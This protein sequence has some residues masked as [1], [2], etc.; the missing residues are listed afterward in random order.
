M[1]VLCSRHPSSH[2][3]EL[4]RGADTQGYDYWLDEL[5]QGHIVRN[6]MIIA[7][8]NGGWDNPSPDAQSDMQRFGFRVE[9]SLAFANY[10]A[11]HGIV[12]SELS[13]QDQ[14]YL[15]EVGANIL[16]NVTADEAT[17]DEAIANIQALLSSLHN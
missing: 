15:R 7:L 14:L 10:Q 4:G 17:R 16:L 2:S 9:V 12:Y 1:G 5:E 11:E 6:H 8:L 13:E 3:S